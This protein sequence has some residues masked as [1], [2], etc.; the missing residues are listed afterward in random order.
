M[1]TNL[2]R[3]FIATVTGTLAVGLGACASDNRAWQ[4]PPNPSAEAVFTQSGTALPYRIAVPPLKDER[5]T[6][7][8]TSSYWPVALPMVPY[9]ERTFERPESLQDPE[10]VDTIEFDP[11]RD[12]SKAIASELNQAGIFSSVTYTEQPD[13]SNA[14]FVLEG[15]LGSTTWSRRVTTYGFGGLGT[16]FWF[17]GAPIGTNTGALEINLRLVP[18]NDRSTTLWSFRMQFNSQHVEGPYYNLEE[19]V[20]KYPRALQYGLEVAVND[21]NRLAKERPEAFQRVRKMARVSQPGK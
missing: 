19:S 5:G 15:T 18:I 3:V 1:A 2:I 10:H 9:A 8:E 6:T 17:L 14:D 16:V 4:Y 13:P 20:L 21:L 11:P 12:L 7:N